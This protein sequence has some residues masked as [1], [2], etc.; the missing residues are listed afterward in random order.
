MGGAGGGEGGGAGLPEIQS[1]VQRGRRLAS[2]GPNYQ[3]VGAGFYLVSGEKLLDVLKLGST[4][5]TQVSI[6][7]E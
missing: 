1:W 7:E 4:G 3:G 5:I 2:G 6:G